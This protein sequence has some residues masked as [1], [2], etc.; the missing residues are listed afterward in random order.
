V[1]CGIRAQIFRMEV[2]IRAFLP[3]GIRGGEVMGRNSATGSPRRSITIMPPSEASR[4]S[5]EVWIW[6]SRTEVFLMMLHCSTWATRSRH[7]QYISWEFDI[8]SVSSVARALVRA[9]S[10]FVSTFVH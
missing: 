2:K 1:T 6:S 10:R 9:A 7:T 4:T 5:F 8:A 3:A